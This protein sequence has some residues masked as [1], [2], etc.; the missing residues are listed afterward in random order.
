MLS[1]YIRDGRIPKDSFFIF[2]DNVVE[3]TDSR[4]FGAVAASD[5]LG[6]FIRQ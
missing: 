4:K 1:L 3:S 5:F 2:G 6:K